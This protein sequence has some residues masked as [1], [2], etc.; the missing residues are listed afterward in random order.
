M[1]GGR[2]NFMPTSS[3][4]PETKAK[5]K[6]TD[7]RNLAKEWTSKTTAKERWSYVWNEKQLQ[8]LDVQ[9]VDHV[10]GQ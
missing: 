3:N 9:K 1:G 8:Q 7:G 6:R 4:D 5:G 10:L 2:Y